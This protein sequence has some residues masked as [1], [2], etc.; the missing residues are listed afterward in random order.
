M[1]NFIERISGRSEENLKSV[2]ANLEAEVAS[3]KQALERADSE[4][5][6]LDSQIKQLKAENIRIEDELVREKASK[7]AAFKNFDD[8]HSQLA[9]EK[10]AHEDDVRNLNSTIAD[11][12][13]ELSAKD[14]RIIALENANS[15]LESKCAAMERSIELAKAPSGVAAPT[16]ADLIQHRE[17]LYMDYMTAQENRINEVLASAD[18]DSDDYP[19]VDITNDP[20]FQHNGYTFV[21][22]E[23]LKKIRG[24]YETSTSSYSGWVPRFVL[25]NG[26]FPTKV[27]FFEFMS[28]HE[29][30]L[31]QNTSLAQESFFYPKCM[32]S[33]TSDDKLIVVFY[34]DVKDSTTLSLEF[35]LGEGDRF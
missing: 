28:D 25:S 23:V 17:E 21:C 33:R 29:F 18:A 24:K 30:R 15:T 20:S 4:K 32:K 6:D 10:K 31:N 8:V 14:T 35:G 12:R 5:S 13:D 22:L 26:Y 2:I 7:A 16:L 19:S 11:M 27:S 34:H 3:Y 1:S 9:A